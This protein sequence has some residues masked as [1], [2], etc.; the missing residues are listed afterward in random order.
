MTAVRACLAGLA[1][2][3]PAKVLTNVD[4]EK[5][6]DTSDEW[7]VT[8]TGIRERRIAEKGES[9]SDLGAAAARKA[10]EQAGI[11]AADLDFIF[12]ASMTP[13][14]LTPSTACAIGHKLGAKGVPAMDISAACSGFLYGLEAARAHL[15]LHPDAKVLLVASEIMSSR[16]NWTDRNTCVLFGDG[17]SAAVLTSGQGGLCVEDVILKSDGAHGEH[18][19]INGGGSAK[20][21][22]LG[23]AV[24]ETF[25][26][27]M[28]GREVFKH[29]VRNMYAVCKDILERNSLS[30]DDLGLVVSHQANKRIISSLGDKLG[31]PE[32]KV[33]INLDKYGN[34]SA[35]SVGIAL[36]E[37][38]EQGLLKPGSRVLL[39][40]MGGG[41]T[42]GSGLLTVS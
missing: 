35:A 41:F 32:D 1:F 33:F 42:W 6:V 4:L 40:A 20:P 8:R 28:N 12:C 15:A 22:T 9:A 27:R 30:V 16:L 24:D 3:V 2:H 34:T 31:L 11:D 38:R 25:F 5:V 19:V 39:A 18:L 17:A 14:S 36:A 29:A 7:I 13:D 10:L 26:L 21:Y 23:Q 37:A